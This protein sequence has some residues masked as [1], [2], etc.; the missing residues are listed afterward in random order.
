MVFIYYP[1]ANFQRIS[2][3]FWAVSCNLHVGLLFCPLHDLTWQKWFSTTSWFMIAGLT[4]DWGNSVSLIETMD[5][6]PRIIDCKSNHSFGE[7]IFLVLPSVIDFHFSMKS[8]KCLRSLSLAS[9]LLVIACLS[10]KSW[11]DVC[12]SRSIVASTKVPSWPSL[13]L[14][15]TLYACSQ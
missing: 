1:C 11:I 10:P 15:C 12:F 4:T 9:S 13:L 7:I 8:K 2:M 3:V 14:R 6:K 5:W